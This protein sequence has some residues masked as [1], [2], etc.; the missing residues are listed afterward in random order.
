MNL[1]PPT[2]GGLVAMNPFQ[3]LARVSGKT[4]DRSQ[5]ALG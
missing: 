4:G 3:C 2:S 1:Y 5:S